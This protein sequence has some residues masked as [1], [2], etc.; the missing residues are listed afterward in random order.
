V[1]CFFNVIDIG[2]KDVRY[3][4][5]NGVDEKGAITRHPTA[6]RDAETLAGEV[7][8]GLREAGVV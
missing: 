7:I 1:K 6:M 4:M 2:K 5:V 8:T 3:L